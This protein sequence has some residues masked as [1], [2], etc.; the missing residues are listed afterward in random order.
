MGKIIGKNDSE[1][2]DLNQRIKLK[3][4]FEAVWDIERQIG[5][6]HGAVMGSTGVDEILASTKGMDF[7]NSQ[8]TI[9]GR[10]LMQL[11]IYLIRNI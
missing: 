4:F 7:L 1:D 2:L 8:K 9:V 6:G 10:Y 5:S 11:A 3:Y